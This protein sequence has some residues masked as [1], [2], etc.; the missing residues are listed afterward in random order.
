MIG[1]GA[2]RRWLAASVLAALA[3]LV[4]MGDVAAQGT[5]QPAVPLSGDALLARLR[6]GGVTLYFR[7]TAT[8]FSQNDAGFVDGDCATQ[9][10][11]NELGRND[12]RMIGAEI[13]RLAIP[14]GEVRASPYCRTL[15]TATLMFGR[16]TPAPEARGGPAQADAD[17][18][19]GLRSLLATPPA[20]RTVRVVAS[21]GN[22]F[23][24]VA[25]PPYLAEGEAAV[26]APGP[27][28]GFTVIAKIT[29]D[30]WGSLG[31]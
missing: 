1:R 3:G 28:S 5:S 19:A 15:E 16:A 22:P 29:K 10:N 4:A 31:R 2:L 7:H 6:A 30:A 24:A 18:Y 14:V 23:Y 13:R 12:A 11:L 25:G 27:G 17:R 26:V 9:R 8:D 20:P 21:H